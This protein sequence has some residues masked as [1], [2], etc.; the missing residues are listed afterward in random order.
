MPDHDTDPRENPLIP[1]DERRNRFGFEP[2]PAVGPKPDG[3][4]HVTITYN[5]GTDATTT[6]VT[7]GPD[8]DPDSVDWHDHIRALHD[9]VLA[10]E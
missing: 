6:V 5:I 8:T 3:D 10:D 9:E 2:D 7:V 1:G 4:H